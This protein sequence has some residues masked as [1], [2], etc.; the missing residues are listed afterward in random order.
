MFKITKV[1]FLPFSILLLSCS[2][3]KKKSHAGDNILKDSIQHYYFLA[4]NSKHPLI[5]RQNNINTSYHLAKK[6]KKDTLFSQILYQKNLLHFSLKEYDSLFFYH[7][8]LINHATNINDKYHLGQQYYLKGYY[9]NIINQ[10]LDSAFYNYN[11]SKDY[12]YSAGDSI[13]VGKNLLSM[14]IIQ[15]NSSD[16]FGSKETLTEA[17]RFLHVKKDNKHIASTYNAIATN[18]RKLLN[19]DD[20]I[21]SYTKAIT[22]TLSKKDRL[23]YK[24]N[25]ATTYTDNKQYKK[26]IEILEITSKD[27]LTINDDLKYARVIDNLAYAKWLSGKNKKNTAFL[28]ALSIRKENNDKRGQIAS[29]THLGEFY[30]KTNPKKSI[31]YFDSV[32]QLSKKLKIPKAEKDALKFLMKID[33]KNVFIRDRYVALNDSLYQ[34]E[35]KVKTQF[36]KYKYDDKLKQED[37]LRLEKEKAEKE[38]EMAKQKTRTLI[39]YF[40]IAL[41]LLGICFIIYYSKQRNKRLLQKNKT[42]RLAATF[43]TEAQLARRVHDDFGARLNHSM[44]LVQ[45][46][47][48]KMIVLDILESLY[49][50]SRNFS[51]EI[52]E[53][54]TGENYIEELF[55]M[56]NTYT[57]NNKLYTIGAKDIDWTSINTLSK[58]VLFKVLR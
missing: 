6:R 40:G 36:A 2:K 55:Q 34:Q 44:S 22:T 33:A 52:N 56:F 48:D 21:N 31:A 28:K 9:F 41:L 7:N 1:F 19:Y 14:G 8:D 39:S 42:E 45:N 18:H 37:I 24:N 53:I 16:F 27:S 47:T 38:V 30:T 12:F 25:L 46:N 13:R 26:A 20:A 17:L 4:K 57:V 32:I 5:N 23:A 3:I 58:T 15:Q 10:V 43:E 54:D 50:Q 29:Y 35:L 49:N 11:I 51:R